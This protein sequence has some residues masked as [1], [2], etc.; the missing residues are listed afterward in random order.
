MAA[1]LIVT[2]T[3]NL[4]RHVQPHEGHMRVYASDAK[5]CGARGG[6]VRP[7]HPQTRWA[8]PRTNPNSN[9][10]LATH[11]LTLTLTNINTDPK[12]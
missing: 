5:V 8:Y 2:L 6:C 3:P 10:T 9:R 12:S 1:A 4:S 11:T 7:R